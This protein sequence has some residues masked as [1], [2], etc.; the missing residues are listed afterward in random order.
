MVWLS[1]ASLK[2]PG[3]ERLCRPGQ[4]NLQVMSLV[5]PHPAAWGLQGDGDHR[6][7][8]AA[9]KRA[10]RDQMMAGADRVFPGLSSAV[11]F[12]EVAT[13]Y[14]F[15]RY[16]GTTDGTSYGIALTADQFAS[17]RPS[18]KTPIHGLFLVGASTGPGT[19]SAALWPAVSRPRL[20]CW[21][22][23]LWTQCDCSWRGLISPAPLKPVAWSFRGARSAAVGGTRSVVRWGGLAA[24]WLSVLLLVARRPVRDSGGRIAPGGP[25]RRSGAAREPGRFGGGQTPGLR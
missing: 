23:P 11:I 7:V 15:S 19:G 25:E 18:P 10:F 9:A 14:T 12:E 2:D 16:M 1:V 3:N 20:R 8:Y 22:H 24:G 17:N 5:P 4:T 6:Q 21:D 13:P